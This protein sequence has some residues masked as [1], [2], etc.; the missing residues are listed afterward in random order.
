VTAPPAPSAPDPWEAAYLRFQT[1]EQEI[2][3]F[4]LRLLRLGARRWPRDARIVELFCGRGNGLRALE[5]MGFT[6]LEGV[7][8][9]PSRVALYRGPA[10]CHVADCRTLPFETASCDVAIVQGGLHH[11]ERL[12]DDLERTLDEVRRVLRPGGRLVVVEPWLTPFLHLVHFAC[13]QPWL[14]RVV[15]KLDAFATMTRHELATYMRWLARPGPIVD[16]LER[17]FTTRKRVIGW[18]KLMYLGERPPG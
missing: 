11:L 6:R 18:G 12:P 9:S 17:R 10:T 5:R 13:R 2:R 1:P 3:K 14:T 4:T 16:A 8:L 15:P 7:D